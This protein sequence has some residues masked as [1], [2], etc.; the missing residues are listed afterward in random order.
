MNNN[1][2]KFDPNIL[3]NLP[4]LPSKIRQKGFE[5]SRTFGKQKLTL[6]ALETLNHLDLLTLFQ[7]VKDYIE[8]RSNYIEAGKLENFEVLKGHI[9]LEKMVKERGLNNRKVNRET[10]WNSIYRFQSVDVELSFLEAGVIRT[11]YIFQSITNDEKNLYDCE[12]FINKRFF[13]FC[14]KNGIIIQIQRLFH[15]KSAYSI[16]LDVFIQGTKWSSYN[17]YLIW[18]RIGLNDTNLPKKEK[19]RI[20]RKSFREIK[21]VS[22]M[23][24]KF[25]KNIK[26]WFGEFQHTFGEFQHT[27]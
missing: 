27:N 5:I 7:L 18:D 11:R 14:V 8:N 21:L 12:V 23:D 1:I 24:F 4:F 15:Y 19:R 6:K 20:V 25:C 3:H 26:K 16:L 9:N 22:G 2:S 10:I 13:D 17:E